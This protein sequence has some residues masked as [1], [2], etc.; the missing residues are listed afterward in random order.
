[1]LPILR[2]KRQLLQ[3]NKELQEKNAALLK[4]NILL[5]DLYSQEISRRKNE[6]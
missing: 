3:E 4:R 1:M 6:R 2:R 5:R